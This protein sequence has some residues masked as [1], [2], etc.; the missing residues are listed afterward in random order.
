MIRKI[1]I[2]SLIPF[3]IF[4]TQ[5]KIKD[6]QNQIEF[7]PQDLN[8]NSFIGN[9]LEPRA[10]FNFHLN[11]KELRLDVGMTR[12]IFHK[13]ISDNKLFSFG[14][15]FFT[16]SKLREEDNFHF[17]VDAIDYLFG[18]NFG[19]KII[20]EK[21]IEYGFRFRV[22][23]ISAHFVDGHFDNTNNQW[24][25]GRKP[26]VYSREFLELLPFFKYDNL[27]TY[28]GTTFLF[29]TDPKDIGK[30]ILQIGGEYYFTNLISKNI[31]P[32]IAYDFKLN[33]IS[34][35]RGNNLLSAGIKFGKYNSYGFTI[36]FTYIAGT[37]IHGEYYN[38]FEKYSTLGI[39]LDF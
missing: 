21:N 19:Y 10:G 36:L 14:G 7:F 8:I 22:S 26:I 35:W 30:W 39:N 9:F 20:K 6:T 18:V 33:K 38:V 34:D 28:F 5:S 3:F 29:H 16:Y 25:N 17:P 15:D 27:R 2:I 4:F 11:E 23:H 13:K 12:D 37:S 1:L 24:R 32:F 31:S